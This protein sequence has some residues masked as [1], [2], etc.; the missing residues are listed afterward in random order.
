MIYSSCSTTAE[1][2]ELREELKAQ[3]KVLQAQNRSLDA[4]ANTNTANIAPKR[5][6]EVPKNL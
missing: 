4:E 6:S 3:T 2:K 5:H 1:V